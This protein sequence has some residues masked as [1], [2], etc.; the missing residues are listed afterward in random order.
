MTAD[1][2]WPPIARCARRCSIH[3]YSNVAA[4][5]SAMEITQPRAAVRPASEEAV[6]RPGKPSAARVAQPGTAKPAGGRLPIGTIAIVV[7]LLAA[8]TVA[9][10]MWLGP[11]SS[12]RAS[13]AAGTATQ[14]NRVHD[15]VTP[16]I[17]RADWSDARL[18]SLNASL[19]ELGGAQIA[20]VAREAWFQHFVDELRQR[21]KEQQALATAPLT[22]DNSPLAALAVT[23]GLDLDSP[24][25]AIH[26]AALPP[27]PS[28]SEPTAECEHAARDTPRN[29]IALACVCPD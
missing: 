27:P 1:W 6:T 29:G 26:I 4:V 24:D 3:S 5:A 15:L 23:V 17:D 11:V 2:I 10:W 25:A 8:A 13:D 9:Y 18:A 12:G 22:V 20:V 7:A 28:A 21:L 19:L 14:P 16:F